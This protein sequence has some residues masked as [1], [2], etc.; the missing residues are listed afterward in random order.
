MTIVTFKASHEAL[1]LDVN[2]TVY[3]DHEV[4]GWT[5]VNKK[6]MRVSAIVLNSDSTVDVTLQE[7]APDSVY[8]E[9]Q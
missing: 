9:N 4:P 1:K 3:V 5:G 8:I 6:K 2:D 7:Y